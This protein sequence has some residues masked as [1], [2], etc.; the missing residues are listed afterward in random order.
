MTTERALVLRDARGWFY[1]G[2]HNGSLWEFDVAVST[3]FTATLFKSIH[4]AY[5]AAQHHF[6]CMWYAVS[7][8]RKTVQ[9]IEVI[10]SSE[11]FVLQHKNRHFYE[12]VGKA[13]VTHDMQEASLVTGVELWSLGFSSPQDWHP[14]SVRTTESL[15]EWQESKE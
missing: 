9:K 3:H 4:E 10:D 13:S 1:R 2:I 14:I 7:V 15:G 5:E 6:G 12:G 11:L 8:E